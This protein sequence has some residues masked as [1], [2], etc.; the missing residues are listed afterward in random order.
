M[1]GIDSCIPARFF[2]T[3]D[4][5]DETI[6][7]IGTDRFDKD[8]ASYSDFKTHIKKS[9]VPSNPTRVGDKTSSYDWKTLTSNLDSIGLLNEQAF[10]TVSAR[11]LTGDTYVYIPT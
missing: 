3:G 6:T 9:Y 2:Y 11:Y 5:P 7:L 4:L 8:V 10:D 1:R